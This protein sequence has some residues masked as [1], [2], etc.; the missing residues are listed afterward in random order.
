MGTSIPI[1][2]GS[3]GASLAP[4]TTLANTRDPES[5]PAPE[6]GDRLSAFVLECYTAAK[7]WTD[8]H[9]TPRLHQCLRQRRGEYDPERLAAIRAHGGADTY[10]NLT[11]TKC[12]AL[13]SWLQDVL[14]PAL[15]QDCWD[16]SPTPQPELPEDIKQSILDLCVQQFLPQLQQLQVLAAGMPPQE[17]E[18]LMGLLRDQ[19][20]MASAEL[21]EE[22]E[23]LAM[24][25]AR[26]RTERMRD[27]VADQLAEGGW[28]EALQGLIHDIA[29]F[30]LAVLKGPILET[31]RVMQWAGETAQVVDTPRVAFRCVSPFDIFPSPNARYLGDD[32]VCELVRFS[33]RDLQTLSAGP[34]WIGPRVQQALEEFIRSKQPP[35]PG[36]GS[37]PDGERARLEVRPDTPEAWTT[38]LEAIE[39]WGTVPGQYL[40]DWANANARELEEFGLSGITA[41]GWYPVSALLLGR[42]V[43]RVSPVLDPL[44]ELPYSACSFEIQAG[45]VWGRSLPEKM[46]DCQDGYT[47]SLRNL[48]NNLAFSSGPC[49]V[50]DAHACKGLAISRVQPWQVIPFDGSRSQGRFPA[51]WWQPASSA[52]LFLK[53]AEYFSQQAD[54]RS[55]VPR[56]SYGN[57]QVTGA[58]QTASGLSMLLSTAAKGIKRVLS[59]L[60]QHVIRTCLTRLVRFNNAYATDPGL[61]GDV[62][63][64]PRGALYA[65]TRDTQQVRQREFLAFASNYREYLTDTGP[66]VILRALAKQSDL[67]EDK[68]VRP[69]DEIQAQ[70]DAA[71]AF[72]QQQAMAGPAG[73]AGPPQ[74]PQGPRTRPRPAAAPQPQQPRPGAEGPQLQPAPP[75]NLPV[76]NPLEEEPA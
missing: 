42:H 46:R 63:V 65:L 9:I 49:L 4:G 50:Y 23:R 38:Q 21:H 59:H 72:A 43:V 68:I 10:F 20:Q 8:Q 55:M 25:A 15:D 12:A 41:E 22:Y 44:G 31:Q 67:P 66:A 32:W 5:A 11:E 62:E 61:H 57:E 3:G 33:A 56:Y 19:V 36:D 76:A 29:T 30:P 45:S 39:W 71:R 58:G 48:V 13:E 54:D 1:W 74:P 35:P 53:T 26:A 18:Q 64:V 14:S 70:A 34:G 16:L 73:P 47:S 7:A 37:R 69:D 40:L 60:D 52:D 51:Q 28:S 75:Q 17:A 6:F 24:D 2:P 27:R